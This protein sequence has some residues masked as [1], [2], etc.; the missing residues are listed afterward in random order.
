MEAAPEVLAP[1]AASA[2]AAAESES[3]IEAVD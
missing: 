1:V 3:T 2:S